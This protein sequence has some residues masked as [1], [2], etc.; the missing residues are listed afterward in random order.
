VPLYIARSVIDETA[1]HLKRTRRH[2]GVAYW[3]G[4]DDGEDSVVTTCV[5]PVAS[6]SEGSYST[7]VRANAKVV[8]WLTA[9]RLKLVGQVHSHPDDCVNHS[10]G[11]D[12]GAFMPYE[13]YWSVVVP[14]YARFGLLPWAR[15]GIHRYRNGHFDRLDRQAVDALIVVV[16]SSVDLSRDYTESL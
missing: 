10:R 7:S 16:P 6:T 5:V 4:L 3:A 8:Q 2:E 1:R 11:D 9:H 14:H 15:C 13:G 12:G